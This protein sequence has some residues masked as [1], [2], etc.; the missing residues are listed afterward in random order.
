M[1]V[2]KILKLIG[3][4]ML[5]VVGLAACDKGGATGAARNN[6]QEAVDPKQLAKLRTSVLLYDEPLNDWQN[7]GLGVNA[8]TRI[9][10]WP[11]QFG[12]IARCRTDILG[13]R[14][15][16]G[17]LAIPVWSFTQMVRCGRT[18][19]FLWFKRFF[20]AGSP[21]RFFID[22]DSNFIEVVGAEDGDTVIVALTG[23]WGELRDRLQ[24]AKS[25]KVLHGIAATEI[26][27]N[28]DL[29]A[30]NN[31]VALMEAMCR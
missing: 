25:V 12:K 1:K 15:T 4:S 13:R 5:F 24:S 10:C 14:V 19:E 6:V 17:E 3:I 22:G 27:Y 9:F 16:T 7:Q 8:N 21:L 2:L 29:S 23:K 11:D 18:T 28:Y 20:G 30:Y 31:S 26:S